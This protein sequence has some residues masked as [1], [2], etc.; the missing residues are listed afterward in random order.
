MRV[1]PEFVEK[2]FTDPNVVV[3]K[4]T[5]ELR[6]MNIDDRALLWGIGTDDGKRT[7][8]VVDNDKFI[9][10]YVDINCY[11]GSMY[12]LQQLTLR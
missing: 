3:G 1:R 9:K 11:N 8:S 12:D 10:G 5:S 7:L 6:A 2:F 4:K